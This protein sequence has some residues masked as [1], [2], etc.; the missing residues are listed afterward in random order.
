MGAMTWESRH[1]GTRID[2]SVDEVYGYAAN[3]ANLPDW[4]PGLCTSVEQVDGAWVAESGM[5][6]V[7][8]AFAPRNSFGVLDHH[9]TLPT[10]ETVYNPMRVI[11]DGDGCEVVFT[12][13]RGPT[14]SDEEY[15]RDAA[16]V[17]ADLTSLKRRFDGT[18]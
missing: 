12:L 14:T 1:I 16:A 10:G 7:V 6:R 15:E 18:P 8:L 3:P 9:V 2:R 5:G 17:L 11:P 4:A 13:R